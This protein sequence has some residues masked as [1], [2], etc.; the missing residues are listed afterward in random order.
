VKLVGGRAYVLNADLEAFTNAEIANDSIRAKLY[1]PDPAHGYYRATR[2]DWSGVIASLEYQG[3][4]YFGPWFE[5]YD[6]KINDAISGPVEEFRT[7]EAGLGYA[8]AKA[9]DTFIRIGV[10]VVRKPD[11]PKYDFFHTYEIVDSGKWTVRR[12][13]DR[14]EFTHTLADGSGYA[15]VYRK[16]VGLAKD[17]PRLTLEHSLKNTGRKVIETSVYDHNFFVIDGQA[18]GPDFA[19]RFPFDVRAARDL[20]KLAET[21]AKEIVYLR[22]L[23]KDQSVFTELE[24]FGGTAAD[25]DITVENRKAGAGVRITGDRPLSKLVFWSIRTTVCPE[26]YVQMRIEPGREFKWRIA[27]DFYTLPGPGGVA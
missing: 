11:E 27:Y 19:V 26:A 8:E 4:N 25:Y 20:G 9:G 2:F 15:Y 5:H 13:R 10:G 21:R 14:V 1:L 7:N 16:T 17:K 6:P 18:S 3:H 12:G 23:E 24:G 22:E